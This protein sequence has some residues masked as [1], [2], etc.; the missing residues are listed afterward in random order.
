RCSRSGPSARRDSHLR[1]SRSGPSAR[2]DSHL[3]C[4][5]SGP[6]ARRDVKRLTRKGFHAEMSGQIKLTF[7]YNGRDTAIRTRVSRRRR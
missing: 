4:S 5:R 1:C 2:R 3:R 6:S 7:C